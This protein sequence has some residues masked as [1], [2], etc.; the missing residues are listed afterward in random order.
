MNDITAIVYVK[1]TKWKRGRQRENGR[2]CH[3]R[4]HLKEA[5]C[6]KLKLLHYITKQ[7][8]V[9]RMRNRMCALQNIQFISL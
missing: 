5:L 7:I 6:E 9:C 3:S 2:E 4:F 8:N 1:Y